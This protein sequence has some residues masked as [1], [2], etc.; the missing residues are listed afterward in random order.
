MLGGD[1]LRVVFRNKN[2][3]RIFHN[4]FLGKTLFDMFRGQTFNGKLVEGS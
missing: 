4:K 1:W 3:G 2:F